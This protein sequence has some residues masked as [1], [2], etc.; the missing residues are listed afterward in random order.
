MTVAALALVATLVLAAAHP[1]AV[2]ADN[3]AGQVARLQTRQ[4]PEAH[5]PLPGHADGITVAETYA[6]AS[7]CRSSDSPRPAP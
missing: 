4:M 3:P 5:T 6:H 2:I 1:G 7:N